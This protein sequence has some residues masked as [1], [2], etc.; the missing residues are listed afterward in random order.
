MV[1]GVLAAIATAAFA[2]ATAGA[3]VES[4]FS[5]VEIQKSGHRAGN[6]FV[7]RGVLVQ[8]GDRDNVLGTDR[9]K[10]SRKGNIH[11]VLFFPDGKLKAQGNANASRII[12]TGGTRRWNGAAGKVKFRQ[13]SRRRTLLNISVVQ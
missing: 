5:V 3:R 9:V 13:L 4:K 12:I 10:F 1:L 6:R 7:T 11:A 8:P 2:A